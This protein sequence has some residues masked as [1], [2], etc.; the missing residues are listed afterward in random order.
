MGE[1]IIKKY[2]ITELSNTYN[3]DR[4]IITRDKDREVISIKEIRE[5]TSKNV[6]GTLSIEGKE[7]YRLGSYLTDG[8]IVISESVFDE[9]GNREVTEYVFDQKFKYIRS[10]FNTFTITSS[11]E[12]NDKEDQQ[13][14]VSKKFRNTIS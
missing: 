14:R 13:K 8:N 11:R 10:N 4:F 12:Y 3:G 5:D 7:N 6:F 1:L 9:S 2:D